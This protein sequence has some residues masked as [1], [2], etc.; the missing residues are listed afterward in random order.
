MLPKQLKS[1]KEHLSNLPKLDDKQKQL[2]NELN[3]VEKNY[4][5]EGYIFQEKIFESFAVA[6]STCPNCGK[7]M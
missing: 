5:F 7:N 4:T 3:F 1:I 2:L 6:S